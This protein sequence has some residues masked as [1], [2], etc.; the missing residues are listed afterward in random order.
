MSIIEQYAT[1]VIQKGVHLRKGQSLEISTTHGTYYFAREL[2]KKAYEL[3]AQYVR[4]KVADN[5]LSRARLENQ[6][7]KELSYVPESFIDGCKEMLKEDWARVAI[8][9]SDESDLLEGVDSKKIGIATKA[10]REKTNFY[11]KEL[12]AHKHPWTVIAVPTE[13]W[14]KKVLGA[15]GSVEQLWEVLKPIIRLDQPDPSAAWDTQTK[16]LHSRCDILNKMG[17]HYL[18]F[19][20]EGTDLRVELNKSSRWIG[21]PKDLP[22]GDLFMPNIPTEEIFTTPNP[23]GTEG[24][25]SFKKPVDIMGNQILGGTVTFQGGKAVASSADQGA[26]IFEEYLNTDEGARFLGEV[27]LVPQNSP[28]A[29]S[30][31]LFHTILYDENAACHIALGAG[32]PI[33]LENSDS[34]VDEATSQA[35][36]CNVSLVH[37][38]CMI[39]SE[40]TKITA[41]T[42]DGEEIVIMEKGLFTGPLA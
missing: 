31:L 36:G 33:C 8:T 21:G 19:E 1:L 40:G 32:Y 34:I 39:S 2:G 37:T 15:E 26:E 42:W 14:A 41:T 18:R 38:D 29:E 25:V 27:A 10:V 16:L 13:I 24:Y 11:S 5:H 7:D 9:P 17:I 30:G 20:D 23:K 28:I 3:G 35:A 22:N 12:M 4:I 6:S